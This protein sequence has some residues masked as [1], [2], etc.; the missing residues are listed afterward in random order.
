MKVQI[1]Y[2]YHTVTLQNK[3]WWT[4][5]SDVN[6]VRVSTCVSPGLGCAGACG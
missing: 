2:S 6:C 1:S 5:S 3:V 4:V